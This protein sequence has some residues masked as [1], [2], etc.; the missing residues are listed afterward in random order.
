[1]RASAPVCGVVHLASSDIYIYE[2]RYQ[3][4]VT[5]DAWAG[6]CVYEGCVRKTITSIG[7]VNALNENPVIAGGKTTTELGVWF[8]KIFEHANQSTSNE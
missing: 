8:S 7:S 3:N 2:R 4:G 1:M 5:C 6:C